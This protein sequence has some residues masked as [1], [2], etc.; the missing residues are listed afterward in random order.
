MAT[1][2]RTKLGP[3]DHGVE[4]S[5]DEFVAARYKDGFKYELIDGRLYVSPEPD[6]PEDFL[7]QWLMR[8]IFYYQIDHPT[9]ITYVSAKSRVFV[10][11]RSATTCPEP[12]LAIY[13]A[14]LTATRIRKLNWRKYQPFIIAEVMT[15]DTWKDLVRNVELYLLVPRVREYWVLDARKDADEPTLI[16][17]ARR[18]QQWRTREYPFGSTFSTKL[19]PGFHLVID[20]GQRT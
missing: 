16:V 1:V 14:V 17:H 7:S 2:T 20:P 13:D 10:P 12:D 15:R 6:M 11:G 5:Y 8:S 4:L 18:G 9:V 3:A 19:L